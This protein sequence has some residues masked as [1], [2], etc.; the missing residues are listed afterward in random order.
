MAGYGMRRVT[1]LRREEVAVLAGVNAGYYT[2]LEQGR[3]RSD[4]E[5]ALRVWPA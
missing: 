2:R 3:E 1:G 5:Q 4:D